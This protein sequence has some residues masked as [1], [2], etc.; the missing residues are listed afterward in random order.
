[1]GELEKILLSVCKT[2]RGLKDKPEI[3]KPEN[4]RLDNLQSILKKF[5]KHDY[6]W[7]IQGVLGGFIH[8]HVRSFRF[9]IHD[10]I[11]EN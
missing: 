4:V 7:K 5:W 2:I 11:T 6:G 9:L 1:M 10:K 3:G 8:Y